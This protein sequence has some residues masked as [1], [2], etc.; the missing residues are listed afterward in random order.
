MRMPRWRPLLVALGGLAAAAGAVGLSR[1]LFAVAIAGESMTPAFEDGDYA[2]V[3]RR[4]LPEGDAATGLVVCVRGPEDRLLL[5]RV[6]GIPGDSLRIGQDVR[7]GGYPLIEPYAHGEAATES[8]RGVHLLHDGEYLVLGDNRAAS[9]DS[10]DFGPV[11]PPQVEG[12]AWLRYWP[13]ERAGLVRREPRQ[14]A[15]LEPDEPPASESGGLP[16]EA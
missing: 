9:T 4:G 2:L 7:V 10:R 15:P 5:K 3:W 13:P 14:F 6:V 16:I 1:S 11:R 8:F 12:I